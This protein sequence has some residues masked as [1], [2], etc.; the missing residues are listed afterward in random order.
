MS[1]EVTT[2]PQMV[3][4]V[5]AKDPRRAEVLEKGLADLQKSA[6]AARPAKAR[7]LLKKLEPSMT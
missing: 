1:S 7:E 4:N 5:R 6:P 2:F 3:E